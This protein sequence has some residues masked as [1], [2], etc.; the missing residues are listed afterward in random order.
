[1]LAVSSFCLF[2]IISAPDRSVKKGFC[3]IHINENLLVPKGK[4]W[5]TFR[6]DT[7]VKQAG[8]LSGLGG[9][10]QEPLPREGVM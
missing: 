7:A 4:L 9:C 8:A 3:K 6:E 5:Y 1:M 2:L 10:F